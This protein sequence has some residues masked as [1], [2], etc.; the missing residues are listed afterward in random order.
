MKKVAFLLIVFTIGMIPM[1][2]AGK[3]TL[4]IPLVYKPDRE[5]KGVVLDVTQ[6]AQK[7]IKLEKFA[8]GRSDKMK[9]AEN[10]EDDEP[11]PVFCSSDVPDFIR[12]VTRK[13][14]SL[15]GLT[16]SDTNPSYT[17][18]GDVS[19]FFVTEKNTY[20]AIVV[21]RYTL[22]DRNDKILYVGVARGN[23]SNFGRSYKAENYQEVLSTAILNM[24]AALVKQEGFQKALRQ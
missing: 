2:Y 10:V 12:E 4:T 22:K 20:E 13:E 21:V 1:L 9:I 18:V 8:D 11:R 16:I 6:L 5:D 7:P 17:L 3:K 24:V 23:A 14:L 15:L 19:E